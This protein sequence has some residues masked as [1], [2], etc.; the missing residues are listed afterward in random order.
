MACESRGSWFHVAKGVAGL[1]YW[2]PAEL[3]HGYGVGADHET[4]DVEGPATGALY[5]EVVLQV[6][7]VE[8][9]GAW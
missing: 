6:D 4:C 9:E 8:V 7:G 5:A 2:S 3:S 1:E